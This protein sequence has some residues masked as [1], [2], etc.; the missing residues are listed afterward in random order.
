[1]TDRLP[2]WDGQ[3]LMLQYH[4]MA[5]HTLGIKQARYQ[6]FGPVKEYAGRLHG[7]QD[8]GFTNLYD[9]G[10]LQMDTE[11]HHVLDQLA[12]KGYLRDTLVV[13]TADH[14][15]GLG[16]HG[17]LSHTNSVYEELLHIP[18]L[19]LRYRDG[20]ALPLRGF[21]QFGSQID[22]APTILHE[23]GM[24]IPATWSGV[25]LQLGRVPAF[26]FY[27]MVP[28]LGLFDHRDPRHLWKF[29][30][31]R[32]ERREYAFDLS[33]DPGERT[34]RVAHVAPATLALWRAQL[35]SHDRG[36]AASQVGRLD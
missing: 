3:P 15:E 22:I 27:Q 5:A 26:T 4:L 17:L 24:P 8:P 25:P 16:E 32:Y 11:V 28:Y 12:A 31:D 13:L 14:G 2:A 6:V 20:H 10:V 30:V 34:N 21:A 9:G 23:L 7:P 33:T 35:D 18:L 29:F 19:T 36:I 1:V